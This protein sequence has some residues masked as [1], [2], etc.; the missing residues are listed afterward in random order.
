MD[1][2]L[3]LLL[4]LIALVSETNLNF[5]QQS[6][7]IIA[8][9]ILTFNL[10]S[11]KVISKD[12]FRLIVI[13]ILTFFLAFFTNPILEFLLNAKIYILAILV[14][15]Y[16]KSKFVN[17]RIVEFII[18][19]NI[20]ILLFQ[21]F[22]NIFLLPTDGLSFRFKG[23]LDSRPLGLFYN[24]HLSAF[25]IAIYFIYKANKSFFFRHTIIGYILVYFFHS[26]FTLFSYLGNF[27]SNFKFFFKTLIISMIFLFIGLF[28]F[29]S[30]DYYFLLPVSGRFILQQLLDFS[31]YKAILN[32]LPTDYKYYLEMQ[33]VDVKDV[34][35][36][37]V[38]N[39]IGNE[40]Q[41]F[42]LYIE[43]GFV[44]ATAYLYYFLKS[45]KSFQIFIII[46]LIHYGF[47][48]TP[49]IIFLLLHFQ[50]KLVKT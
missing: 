7:E 34:F 45:I 41:L 8:I 43:G 32:P 42:T 49:F 13:Y 39:E 28:F 48:T 4:F 37:A 44:L 19:I 26:K 5:L 15:I 24:T 27:F 38:G 21:V 14:L 12:D 10:I 25:V 23:L 9:F 46:S 2:L 18:F 35:N 6:L 50:N 16:F 1:A 36:K 20:F 33:K 17:S 47:I 31:S 40:V 22:F 30:T 11:R 29:I 3:I